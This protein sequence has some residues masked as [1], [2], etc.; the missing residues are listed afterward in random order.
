MIRYG[1]ERK[2]LR[3]RA[4]AYATLMATIVAV[5]GQVVTFDFCS[6]DDNLHVYENPMLQSVSGKHLAEIWKAPYRGLYIPVSYS[7][8]TA[9]TWLS[10][11]LEGTDERSFN[12][13]VFHSGSLLLHLAS[14]LLVF[15]LLQHLTANVP[16]ALAGALLFGL[17]PLQVE[18]VAWVS[19]T[20]G[21]LSAALSLVAILQYLKFSGWQAD[22]S[23]F[24]ATDAHRWRPYALATV[25]FVAA[26]LAKPSAVTVPLMLLI[27]EVAILRQP[28]RAA[29]VALAP[30]AGIAMV[31][32]VITK[33]QQTQQDMPFLTPS[34][35]R[36]L[37]AGDALAFYLAKLVAP[38]NLAVPYHR[39]PKVVMAQS[40]VYFMWLIPCAALAILWLTRR[41][42]PWLASAGLFVAAILPVL[43]LV[44]FSY[45]TYSTVADRY[46][47]L[48]ML[49]PAIALSFWLSR[50]NGAGLALVGL[51]L[52][53]CGVMSLVQATYWKDS[54]TL[55]E[56]GAAVTEDNHVAYG[57]LGGVAAQAHDYDLAIQYFRKAIAVTP[58]WASAGV[59]AIDHANLG[60]VLFERKQYDEALKETDTALAIDSQ[61]AL[62][63]KNRGLILRATGKHEQ[64]RAAFNRA[65]QCDPSVA[66]S[67][68]Q[69]GI[70]YS[71]FQAFNLALRDFD[72][73]IRLGDRRAEVYHD[74]GSAHLTL[75]NL[76]EAIADYT[77]AIRIKPTLWQAYLHRAMAYASAGKYAEAKLDLARC[78]ALGGQV[79]KELDEQV[80]AQ[81]GI[82]R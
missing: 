7:F 78:R 68:Y 50:R 43:G 48:A 62:A 40:A 60:A 16:A 20:R 21:L 42:G 44:P 51:L 5:F 8:F 73:A 36:P 77:E 13:A 15:E 76:D 52:T 2:G 30:W 58:S 22:R 63:H 75:G 54:K 25:A 18:S 34:W 35:T 70:E 79:P 19:E 41:L 82:E 81:G 38:I 33:W 26:I 56:R 24:S 59:R 74:R 47:Y 64:A 17:H 53:C 57:G 45:Q 28:W 11:S 69:R 4:A 55:F 31:F 66:D 14:V 10:Q 3:S 32:S 80:S 9:E 23:P 71:S 1:A 6:W 37:V 72:A 46:V 12:P 39:A 27:I 49:G 67:Y 65:I 61:F 29:A